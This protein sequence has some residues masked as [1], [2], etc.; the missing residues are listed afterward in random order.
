VGRCKPVSG[1]AMVNVNFLLPRLAQ[2]AFVVVVVVTVVFFVTRVAGDPI[3]LLAPIDA[4]PEQIAELR[5]REG[6]DRPILRQYVDYLGDIVRMELGNS[7]RTGRPA[8]TEV[9]ARVGYTVQ[10][11]LAAIGFSLLV[12][13]PVGVLAAVYRGTFIDLLLRFVALIG[14]AAPNFWLGLILIIVF[15]VKLPVLPTGGSGSLKHLILPAVTLGSFSAAA[16]TRLTRSTM[17]EVLSSDYIR[18]ARS[19][20]LKERVV[21]ARHALR[22]SML[23]V[24]TV[25]GIQ[26]GTIISGAIVVETVFAWPGMGRLMIQSI[27]NADYPVVQIAVML[28]AMTIA[29]VNLLVD[30]SYSWLDPRVKAGSR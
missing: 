5:S 3:K 22:N 23:P 26:V 7:F 17:L 6:L 20:G 9:R 10:L 16:L 12:G 8:I 13:L 19:K 1:P 2:A 27:N 11:G 4:S 18:T 21:I 28:I 30:I 25:L 24:I 15:A 29:V 14:Q